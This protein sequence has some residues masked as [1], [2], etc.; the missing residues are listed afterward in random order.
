MNTTRTVRKDTSV[1]PMN[2]PD[3]KIT[4]RD[5]GDCRI[6]SATGG[7]KTAFSRSYVP[8]DILT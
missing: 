5:A 4:T 2:L 8:P 6:Y 3:F 1:S 7:M